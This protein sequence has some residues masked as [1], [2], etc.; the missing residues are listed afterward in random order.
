MDSYNFRSRFFFLGWVKLWQ[1][2]YTFRSLT[3]VI[4]TLIMLFEVNCRGKKTYFE[5]LTR[6]FE[7]LNS[8]FNKN[9]SNDICRLVMLHLV[10]YVKWS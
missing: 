1:E 9:L 8:R 2:K 4:L 7:E 10:T 3:E 6:V 5:E